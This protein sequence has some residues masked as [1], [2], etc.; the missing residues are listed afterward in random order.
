VI[1]YFKHA[2]RTGLSGYAQTHDD[3]DDGEKIANETTSKS[4][5]KENIKAVAGERE[6]AETEAKEREVQCKVSPAATY[7]TVN[8]GNMGPLRRHMFWSIVRKRFI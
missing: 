5:G 6:K 4:G 7:I 2:R 3:V 1:L 8:F